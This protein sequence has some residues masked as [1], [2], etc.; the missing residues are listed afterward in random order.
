M[1]RISRLIHVAY[2]LSGFLRLHA[3]LV[4][5]VHKSLLVG[6]VDKNIHIVRIIAEDRV[7]APSHDDAALLFRQ[8][9]D[10]PCRGVKDFILRRNRSVS[11]REFHESVA[12]GFFFQVADLPDRDVMLLCH[13]GHD[14]PVI[15]FHAQNFRHFL[16][17]GTPQASKLS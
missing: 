3:K 6:R 1:K 17:N 15:I 4:D 13:H 10:D 9:P 12:G 2:H 14:V 16:C 7:R 5:T 8:L 11:Q